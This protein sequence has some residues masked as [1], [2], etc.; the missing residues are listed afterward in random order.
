M[1]LE[2]QKLDKWT[3]GIRSGGVVNSL[4][5]YFQEFLELIEVECKIHSIQGLKEGGAD[6]RS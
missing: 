1:F 4:N 2:D 6:A 3:F 5:S